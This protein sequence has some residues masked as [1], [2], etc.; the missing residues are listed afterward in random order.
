MTYYRNV[1]LVHL[2]YYCHA[3][4]CKV[5]SHCG[6]D[7]HFHDGS[8]RSEFCALPQTNR[9]FQLQAVRVSPGTGV[10]RRV[11]GATQGGGAASRGSLGCCWWQGG[12]Y[13]F[14]AD[15]P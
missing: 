13:R 3:S 7:L 2:F 6:L 9:T 1:H 10:E 5:V 11:A 15:P 12:E 4:G 14:R 8:F